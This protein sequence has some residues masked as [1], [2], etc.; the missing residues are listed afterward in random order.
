MSKPAF[1]PGPWKVGY[2]DGSGIDHEKGCFT[3]TAAKCTQTVV[4]SGDSFGMVYGVRN[5][6]DARLIAAAPRMFDFIAAKAADGDSEAQA[7]V[8]VINGRA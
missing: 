5:F 2:D 3:I 7:I 6:A 4:W 8:E 1:T